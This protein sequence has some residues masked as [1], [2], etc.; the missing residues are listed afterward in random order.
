ML[1]AN[2][3]NLRTLLATPILVLPAAA[4]AQARDT[5]ASRDSARTELERVTI[6]ASRTAPIAVGGTSAIVVPID[7]LRLSPAPVLEDAL[8]DMPFV[9][10]RQNSRGEVELSVRGSESRQAAILLDGIPLTLGWDGRTDPSIVPLGGAGSVVLVRGLSSLRQG[11]NVLGGVLEIGLN[12]VADAA[13]DARSLGVRAGTDHLGSQALHA[14]LTLPGALGR[15][16][17]TLRT[18]LGWRSRTALQLSDNVRDSASRG[19]RRTNSDAEELDGYVALRAE[20]ERGGW[21]GVSAMAYSAER[22]VPPELH[23][24]EPRLWRYPRQSRG[25]GILSLGTGR[26]KTALGSGDAELV[27]SYSDA[28]TRIES[29]ESLAYD[30]IA[31]TEGG[32]ERA[33]TVRALADHSL[34]RGELRTSFTLSRLRY[35]ETLDTTISDYEQRLWSAAGEI[36][37][38]VRGTLRVSGGLALDGVSTPEAGGKPTIDATSEWAGRLGLSALAFGLTRVHASVNRRAR[39]GALR[40]LYSGSLGRFQPNPT[41]R[42]EILVGGEVGATGFSGRWHWQAVAF[43]HELSD[44]IVRIATPD[45]KFQRVNRDVVRSH[46]LELLAA[47]NGAHASLTSDA[48][49]QRARVRDLSAAGSNRRPEY[50]PDWRVGSEFALAVPGGARGIVNATFTGRQYCVNPDLGRTVALSAQRRFD[51]A[52]ERA[53]VVR[54]SGW[55][56][57]LSAT[58]GVDNVLDAAVFDQC[59]LP[60]PGR[61]FRV[62]VGLR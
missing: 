7:S 31:G 22:G 39:F 48:V 1:Q 41:L 42:P 13:D 6:R 43:R 45:R 2:L 28:D 58:L 17:L 32:D 5:T 50:Q 3:R 57:R 59:G 61:T 20:R 10:V 12:R 46:G 14:D 30:R 33:L 29:F 40:E 38:P 53:Y 44:A 19:E 51:A 34:G 54:E 26:R 25:L 55:L 37:A 60:Q 23:I 56:A 62:A 49:L 9:T 47:W 11:P 8:R 52:L 27:V 35:R 24:S 21:A 18:G 4:L 36:E 15:G 16:F